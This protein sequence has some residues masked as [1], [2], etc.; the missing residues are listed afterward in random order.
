[1]RIMKTIIDG[2]EV[3]YIPYPF[4]IVKMENTSKEQ[5]N[6]LVKKENNKCIK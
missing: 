6:N 1:M 5:T 4:E 3:S 2:I